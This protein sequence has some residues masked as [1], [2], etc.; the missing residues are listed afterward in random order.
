MKASFQRALDFK[1]LNRINMS[2]LSQITTLIERVCYYHVRKRA[3]P[4]IFFGVWG[5]VSLTTATFSLM[6]NALAKSSNWLKASYF[7]P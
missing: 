6:L 3:T 5:L 2:F 1:R 4:T 7:L